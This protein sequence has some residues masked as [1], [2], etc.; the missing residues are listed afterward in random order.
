SVFT[1]KAVLADDS[2]LEVDALQGAPGV[3]SARY[4]GPNATDE[5]NNNL[6]L[7]E[8]RNATDRHAR[9][10]CVLAL[11]QGGRLLTTVR[12]VVEGRILAAPCGHGGFGYDPLFFYP[13]LNRSFAELTSQ[14]KFRV[15]HRGNALRVPFNL[16]PTDLQES[17]RKL[18]HANQAFNASLRVALIRNRGGLFEG[19]NIQRDTDLVAFTADLTDWGSG[20]KLSY[21]PHGRYG[22][23]PFSGTKFTS[24]AANLTWY[25]G[26]HEHGFDEVILLNEDGQISECTSANIFVIQEDRVWTPPL[27]TSGC[28]PG[29]TRAILLEEIQVPGLVIAER[30]LTSSDLEESDQVFVTST[31]RDLLPVLEVDHE[32]LN[33]NRAVLERLQHA[34]LQYRA[35][36]VAA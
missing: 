19:S 11:A 33:Q 12:G 3:Y 8:L 15:S 2:G 10:V 20:L 23:S 17:L 18:I 24:W 16:S 36:Y 9:F 26:A 7:R 21:E 25:E 29:V 22:A 1:S 28:L 30:E 35:R 5:D 4:A 14:E 34:F 27:A 13:P 31:T 32:P 6:L